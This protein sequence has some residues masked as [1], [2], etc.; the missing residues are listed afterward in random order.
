MKKTIDIHMANV[1]GLGAQKFVS[2]LMKQ[3]SVSENI[4]VE[5]L[6]LGKNINEK[7]P[8]FCRNLNHVSYRL[9]G[10][11]RIFEI[12]TWKYLHKNKNSILV[13]G[14]L[15]L[16][17]GSKQ[18]VLCHQGLMFEKYSIFN[19]YFWKFLLFKIVFKCFLKRDDVVIVQT[20]DMAEKIRAHINKNANVKILEIK[21]NSFDWPSFR[22]VS[23]RVHNDEMASIRL[24]YPAAPYP[25]KN[26]LFLWN[27]KLDPSVKIFLTIDNQFADGNP[28]NI[29][30][31]GTISRENVFDFYQN[32]DGLLFLSAC[33]SL[34][35]PILEA[36]KCNLP[37]ICPNRG[38]TAMLES[39]DC[40]Y[41]DLDDIN[42]LSL[43][44]SEMKNKLHSGWWPNWNFESTFCDT[45]S[46][47]LEEILLG[48]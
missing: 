12:I 28:N 5:N 34:G 9:G 6:Y 47:A 18:F 36:V 37:I 46:Y 27:V 40:F 41:F 20:G 32:V 14:D 30:F 31:M 19:R 17:S 48:D 42:S 26:H 35:M 3:L 10:I 22:R 43:A 38:Y 33:E 11:S 44:I 1:I 45:N 24:F 4:D 16:C 23:R 7:N 13:L 21:S 39:A 2:G 25:H 8:C 15:P 29:E